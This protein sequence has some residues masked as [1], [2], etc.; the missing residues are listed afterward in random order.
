MNNRS[1]SAKEVVFQQGDVQLFP[2]SIPNGCRRLETN[3]VQ[4]GE[5]TGHAH[6]LSEGDFEVYQDTKGGVRLRVV[7]PTALKH[8]EHDTRV[9]APGE[10]RI[11]II[12]QWDYDE[13]EARRVID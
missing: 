1:G 9:I 5:L 12:Q 11:G 13:Q 8:E 6:R 7:T 3:V 4:E 10:Y 2:E